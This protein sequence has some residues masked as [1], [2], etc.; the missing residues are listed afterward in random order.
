MSNS[1]KVIAVSCVCAEFLFYETTSRL[2]N[3]FM[4]LKR[5]YCFHQF[6]TSVYYNS[7]TYVILFF[8]LI[9]NFHTDTSSV[10]TTLTI[11]IFLQSVKYSSVIYYRCIDT[12]VAFRNRLADGWAPFGRNLDLLITHMSKINRSMIKLLARKM[13]VLI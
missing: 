1:V 11:K 9:F 7:N 5:F 13:Y 4:S 10:L 2:Q 8:A 6:I 12:R 3:S